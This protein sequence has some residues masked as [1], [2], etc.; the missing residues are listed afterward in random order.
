[1]VELCWFDRVRAVSDHHP[2]TNWSH[3]EEGDFKSGTAS[4]L[5]A[6]ALGL[7]LGL[8]LGLARLATHVEL[9]LGCGSMLQSS[10][11]FTGLCWLV[12][13]NLTQTGVSWDQA[14]LH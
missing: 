5:P 2:D 6:S 7:G 8:R 13:I 11:G 12:F 14:N 4:L 3:L 9:F 10:S 1:M